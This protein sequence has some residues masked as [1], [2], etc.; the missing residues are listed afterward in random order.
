MTRRATPPKAAQPWPSDVPY[1]WNPFGHIKPE[2]VPLFHLPRGD[3]NANRAPGSYRPP[4]AAAQFT[5][6]KSVPVAMR[7]RQLL[8]AI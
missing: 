6:G 2:L 8:T 5:I 3:G 4:S 7:K 1:P